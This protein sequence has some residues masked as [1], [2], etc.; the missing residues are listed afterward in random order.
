MIY[1]LGFAVFQNILHMS[2]LEPRNK[3][4]QNISRNFKRFENCRSCILKK[5]LSAKNKNKP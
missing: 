2:T 5:E 3:S 1:N 4:E